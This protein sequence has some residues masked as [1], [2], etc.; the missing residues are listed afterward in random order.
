MDING[1]AESIERLFREAMDEQELLAGRIAGMARDWDDK[2]AP[3]KETMRKYGIPYC[4]RLVPGET[5]KGVIVGAEGGFL[6][7]LSNGLVKAVCPKTDEFAIE[8]RTWPLKDYVR[9]C[10]LEALK[11]GFEGVALIDTVPAL[12]KNEELA[13]FIRNSRDFVLNA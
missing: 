3:I 6:R 2:L 8:E 1:V 10:D 4:N 5:S 7:V 13:E 9:R 12:K 11:C